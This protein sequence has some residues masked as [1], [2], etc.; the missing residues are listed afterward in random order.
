MSAIS[1]VP[2]MPV[3]TKASQGPSIAVIFSV[4]L[5]IWAVL[6]WTTLVSVWQTGIFIDTDD[7]M[8]LVELRAWLAGQNWF[9][10][11]ATRMDAPL[12]VAMH[13]SRL[14]DV[15]LAGLFLFFHMFTDAEHA[16]RLMRIVFPALLFFGQ[17]S[18]MAR[19]AVKLTRPDAA[20]FSILFTALSLSGMFAAGT[21]DHHGA[22][23]LIQSLLLWLIIESLDAP[24]PVYAIGAG[25]LTALSLQISIEDLPS[26]AVMIASFGIIYAIKGAAYAAQLRGF[27]G[28]FA[29]AAV[30]ALVATVTPE[31]YGRL[32]YDAFS[33]THVGAA[34][35]GGAGFLA[36]SFIGPRLTSMPA[37]FGALALCGGLSAAL[38]LVF[39]PGFL[40][41]PLSKV[42]ELVRHN[43]LERVMEAK[44]LPTL[45]REDFWAY[46][47]GTMPMLAGLVT[48]V[49]AVVREQGNRRAG[50]SIVLGFALIG[51]LGSMWQ[52]R[53]VPLVMPILLLGG[54]WACLQ[55][56]EYGAHSR[57]ALI[58]ILPILLVLPF[59][60]T[61]WSIIL[62]QPAPKPVVTDTNGS[63]VNAQAEND[64]CYAAS[65]FTAFRAL[66]KGTVL[67]TIDPGPHILAFTDHNVISGPFHRDIRGLTLLI[68]TWR[69][70]PEA[71][72]KFVRESGATYVAYCPEA[73]EFLSVAKDKSSL[74]AALREGKLPGWLT[75]VELAGTPY[76]VFAVK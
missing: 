55:A 30:L 64:A 20:A 46:L 39:F 43:W 56:I 24:G 1:S 2:L 48:L 10:M 45:L 70:S 52:V 71:A 14:Y 59:S 25:I 28:S 15:P 36:L 75:P 21:I 58:K 38:I 35:I 72:E 37:R 74:G 66:P 69:S 57:S 13:W 5:A 31:N 7:A 76:K 61:A 42:P 41:D 19:I 60:E 26:I 68:E 49:F 16:E 6:S 23:S 67:S 8:K 9:D 22:Q 17:M 44:P 29:L 32:A 65:A 47:P 18:V 40:A 33:L 63:A 12:G 53:V 3:R 51:V 27:A 4:G 73:N 54:V 34:C 62:P 11:T 50:W